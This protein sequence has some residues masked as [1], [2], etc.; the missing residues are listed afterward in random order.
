MAQRSSTRRST[1][2]STKASLAIK[3]QE[4]APSA[5]DTDTAALSLVTM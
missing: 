2:L 4:E 3:K 1:Q 5:A